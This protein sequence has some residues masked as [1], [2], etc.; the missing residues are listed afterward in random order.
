MSDGKQGWETIWSFKKCITEVRWVK[1]QN[2]NPK[3]R[4]SLWQGE[5]R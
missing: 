2:F 1:E 3:R 5:V 4:G